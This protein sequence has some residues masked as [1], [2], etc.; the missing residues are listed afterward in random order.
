MK[1]TIFFL[2]LA[3]CFTAVLADSKIFTLKLK[4]TS[5][6][7]NG[8]NIYVGYDSKIYL[9]K[10]EKTCKGIIRDDTSLSIS[11]NTMGIGK[12]FLSLAAQSSSWM[13]AKPFTV[14]NG[15]LKLYGYNFHAIP[16]GEKPDQYVLGSINAMGSSTVQEIEILSEGDDGKPIPDFGD[17][18]SAPESSFSFNKLFILVCFIFF[19]VVLVYCLILTF[20]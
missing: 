2:F 18:I 11:D 12:N 6:N 8:Y 7:L 16:S 14:V 17:L 20:R 9:E 1:A 4:D 13:V 5:S 15:V 3:V 10:T 19:N